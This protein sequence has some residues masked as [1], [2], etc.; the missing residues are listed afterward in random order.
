MTDVHVCRLLLSYLCCGFGWVFTASMS[1]AR[2]MDCTCVM[3]QIL[4]PMEIR[5]SP[6]TPCY[7]PLDYQMTHGGRLSGCHG[8]HG[9]CNEIRT[10]PVSSSGLLEMKAGMYSLSL[11]LWII[12][13][14][15]YVT[16]CFS[17]LCSS[18]PP[19][20]AVNLSHTTKC[21]SCIFLSIPLIIY[22][23]NLLSN[24]CYANLVL[25]CIAYIYVDV[26]CTTRLSM[27]GSM[28]MITGV[29]K[30]GVERSIAIINWSYIHC[31]WFSFSF[32]LR[33]LSSTPYRPV[34]YEGGGSPDYVSDVWAPMYS[35]IKNIR[36]RAG[37]R[38][39]FTT[40]T[41]FVLP[42]STMC[43]YYCVLLHQ[44][45]RVGLMYT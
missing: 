21:L 44:C 10:T 20:V 24:Y 42:C 3:R 31:I 5:Y 16:V 22:M 27:T 4:K 19:C 28:N 37:M 8:Q 26:E 11:S 29:L 40:Y 2:S 6:S 32:I 23:Y 35:T 15:N 41:L 14:Y 7:H 33:V 25:H 13:G 36:D 9:C 34:Q 43:M 45:I 38:P 18:P 30:A 17:G 39:L 1:Y 12:C